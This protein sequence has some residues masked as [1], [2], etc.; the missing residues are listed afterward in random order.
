MENTY[1][2][3]YKAIRGI[4][5]SDSSNDPSYNPSLGQDASPA[6][7][8]V[9]KAMS[10]YQ[11]N[12]FDTALKLI[13][14][15]SL[16]D[17]NR[18]DEFRDN[19]NS[20]LKYKTFYE[21]KINEY[22]ARQKELNSYPKQN[23][24]SIADAGENPNSST[25]RSN[26]TPEQTRTYAENTGKV[27]DTIT[28]PGSALLKMMGMPEQIPASTSV[29]YSP[30]TNLVA[31][32]SNADLSK[33]NERDVLGNVIDM[34]ALSNAGMISKEM[35]LASSQAKYEK[36]MNILSNGIKK[37]YVDAGSWTKMASNPIYE[38]TGLKLREMIGSIDDPILAEKASD[39]LHN[40]YI[41][42]VT[43]GMNVENKSKMGYESIKNK[44]SE[45]MNKSML[46]YSNKDSI[47]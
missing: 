12:D 26:Y 28:N 21:Q 2:D 6:S 3:Y 38:D 34:A 4:S 14:S 42:P 5:N 18:A 41:Q 46:E 27:I 23:L 22:T 39:A 25:A 9:R 35:K 47:Q 24:N 17:P 37:G 33:V 31:K 36:F 7:E 16:K 43:H 10:A 20:L 1:Q 32:E 30:M 15:A 40:Q 11:S 13:S 45:L 19:I 8:L 29:K 44:L